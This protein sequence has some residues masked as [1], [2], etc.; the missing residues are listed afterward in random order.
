MRVEFDMK[1][2]SSE[3]VKR[4][5]SESKKFVNQI[6]SLLTGSF[7]DTPEWG[8]DLKQTGRGAGTIW[9]PRGRAGN[10]RR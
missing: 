5:A 3:E 8:F 1:G 9:L 10:A 2:L 4:L 6:Q 7:S